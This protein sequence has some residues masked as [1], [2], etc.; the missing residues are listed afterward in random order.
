MSSH[1]VTQRLEKRSGNCWMNSLRERRRWTEDLWLP[2]QLPVSPAAPP[3]GCYCQPARPAP[4][5]GDRICEIA[6][7][8]HS[9]VV[10][11]REDQRVNG[12]SQMELLLLAAQSGTRVTVE[13]D[14]PDAEQALTPLAEILAAENIDD[15]SD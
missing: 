12:K 11:I 2:R 1:C 7:E 13:V 3:G 9:N 5:S 15:E 8:F 14:G 6:R 10:V 4:S